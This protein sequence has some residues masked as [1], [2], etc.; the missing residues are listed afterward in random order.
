M[1]PFT[2]P[3]TIEEFTKTVREMYGDG[4]TMFAQQFKDAV[5]QVQPT[6]EGANIWANADLDFLCDFFE[7]WYAWNPD[8]TTGLD[9]IEKFAWLYYQNDAGLT[10]VKNSGFLMTQFYVVLNAM[11][12][13]SP[14]SKKLV[15]HWIKEIGL[16]KIKAEYVYPDGGYP[17][18]NKFFI[19]K[20]LKPRPVSSPDDDSVV[21][22][23]ADAVVNMVDDNLSIDKPQNVKTQKLSVTQLLDNSELAVNFEGGTAISCILMPSVYHHYHA[24]VTGTVVEANE[25]VAGNYFGIDDFPKLVNGG[26]VGYGYD[27][28]VFEHFKRGYLIIQTQKFGYVAMIPVGLNTIASVIFKEKFKHV[29]SQTPQPITKGEEVGYFQYGGS[30]NILLFQKGCFPAIR[31][32]QG[33]IIGTMNELKKP[34]A[35][36]VV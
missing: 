26:N 3:T 4:T 14:N 2:Q 7:K 10:F 12:M 29:T 31:I 1:S 36:F 8:L 20:L 6:P 24:P 27:Y 19:R 28:S 17:N 30:L 32:P 33:Q 35:Q 16:D 25:D 22:C 34:A 23:P 18:F 11:K 5:A 13:D 9:F 15:D 21:A